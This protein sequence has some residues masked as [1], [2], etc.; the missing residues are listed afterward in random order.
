MAEFVNLKLLCGSYKT[1]LNKMFLQRKPWQE[2]DP[3]VVRAFMPGT[4]EGLKVKVGGRGKEGD[5]LM[6]FRA[7]K[8]SNRMLAPVGGKVTAVNVKT[9]ENVTKNTEMIKIE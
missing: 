5:V 7:M 2:E 3:G 4:V 8:M 1:T 6:I 9:G